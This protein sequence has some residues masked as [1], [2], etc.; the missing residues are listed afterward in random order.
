[1]GLFAGIEKA[2]IPDDERPDRKI[3]AI[4]TLHNGHKFRSRTEARWAVFLE[5]L[6]VAYEYEKEWVKL[7]DVGRHLP[8]FYLPATNR[9]VQIKGMEPD[10]KAQ[11][12]A[13]E[14]SRLKDTWVFIVSG[15]PTSDAQTAGAWGFC[16]GVDRGDGWT[17][18]QIAS[19]SEE[20]INRAFDAADAATFREEQRGQ[21]T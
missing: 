19:A 18:G 9:Y 16:R 8:D 11:K 20:A 12:Q 2:R 7:P 4:K 13:K 21:G 17:W 6:G 10:D 1:M 5:A 14:L 3:R 15:R